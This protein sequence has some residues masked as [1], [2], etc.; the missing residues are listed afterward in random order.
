[1]PLTKRTTGGRNLAANKTIRS[2]KRKKDAYQR[3]F[4]FPQAKGKTITEVGLFVSSSYYLIEIRFQD[5]TALS[6][7]IEPCVSSSPKLVDGKPEIT[8]HSKAGGPFTARHHGNVR[9]NPLKMRVSYSRR[10]PVMQK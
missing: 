1:M 6:F 3:V 5:K 7:D 8:N 10:F 2:R 4:K 9:A